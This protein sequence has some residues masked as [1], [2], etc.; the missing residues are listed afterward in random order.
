M[1]FRKGTRWWNIQT[2]PYGIKKMDNKTQGSNLAT[3]YEP[4]KV[5]LIIA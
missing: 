5:T 4:S 2:A 3:F 1:Q